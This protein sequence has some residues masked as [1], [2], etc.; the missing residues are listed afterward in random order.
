MP[1]DEALS[2]YGD[3]PSERARLALLSVQ[4]EEAELIEK[5]RL[6]ERLAP[7]C[8]IHIATGLEQAVDQRKAG[9]AG[10]QNYRDRAFLRS[11][12]VAP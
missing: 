1:H 11:I 4:K 12:G 2:P 5:L 3:R 8:A 10:V 9:K 6:L 7:T